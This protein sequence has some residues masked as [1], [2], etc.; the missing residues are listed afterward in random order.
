MG[1]HLTGVYLMGTHLISVYPMGYTSWACTSWAYTTGCSPFYLVVLRD[2]SF[3]W[4]V[5]WCRIS[6]FGAKWQVGTWPYC[7][8]YPPVESQPSRCDI[9][10]TSGL[11]S[12]LRGP[13]GPVG[14][15]WSSARPE[16]RRG[17]RCKNAKGEGRKGR[18][19]I[20]GKAAG[21]E[22]TFIPSEGPGWQ[23]GKA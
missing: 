11:I 23:T 6:H 10:P 13:G 20:V 15:R 8:R 17:G 22:C 16:A 5:A 14:S 21:G 4:S 3:W 7:P 18:E 2:C 12:V 9:F 19:G 1:M